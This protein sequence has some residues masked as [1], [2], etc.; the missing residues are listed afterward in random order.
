MD[1]SSRGLL[2]ELLILGIPEVDAQHEGIFYRIENL[3]FLCLE[4]NEL[5]QAVVVDLLD[6]LRE[7]FETEERIAAA[8]RLD[9]AEH[10]GKHAETLT[11]LTGWATVVFSGQRDVF[12][13]LRYLEIWFERHIREEDQPFAAQLLDINAAP[14]S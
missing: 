1:I 9:F 10:A 4:Q 12:S 6:Y 2:P 13:F 5:P 3:K 14:A 8:T 7:H 11:T